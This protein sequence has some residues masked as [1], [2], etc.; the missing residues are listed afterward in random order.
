MNKLKKW[1]NNTFTTV[2]TW[3][4]TKIDFWNPGQFSCM[5]FIGIIAPAHD[6]EV[7]NFL[8]NKYTNTYTGDVFKT[9]L[10]LLITILSLRKLPENFL[11]Y[12]F[13]MCQNALWHILNCGKSS[14]SE[15]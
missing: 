3:K 8:L 10:S 7:N 11:K 13:K 15:N 12:T 1:E 4:D 2:R 6:S 14:P 9:A 5:G